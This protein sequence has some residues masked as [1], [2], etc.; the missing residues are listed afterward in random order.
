MFAIEQLVLMA[1]IIGTLFKTRAATSDWRAGAIL[2]Q[3][4]KAAM[5]NALQ[6]KSKYLS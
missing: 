6:L 3:W 4:L 2:L 1:L 5:S